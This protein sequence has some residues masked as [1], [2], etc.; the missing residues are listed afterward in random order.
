MKLLLLTLGYGILSSAVPLFNMEAYIVLAY[1]RSDAAAWEVAL[2]GSLGMNLGKL[3]WYYLA[4]GSMQAPFLQRRLQSPRRKAQLEKWTARMQARPGT[5]G[6]LTFGSAL[7]GVPPFF[8]MA[9]VAG[10]LR[11]NVVVFFL[12]GLAGRTLFFWA[13]LGGAHLILR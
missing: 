5:A 10:T 9:I 12:A 4:R 11:M 8:V 6:V 3:V 1:A 13:I 2:V 7:I